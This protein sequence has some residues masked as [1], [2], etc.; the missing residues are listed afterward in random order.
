MRLDV[1]DKFAKFLTSAYRDRQC[2]GDHIVPLLDTFHQDEDE[3]TVYFVFPFLRS[4]DD[5][6]METIGD[7]IDY[8]DQIIDVR[9]CLIS[10]AG[11]NMY[12]LL[13]RALSICIL[14]IWSIGKSILALLLEI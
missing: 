3:S 11:P 6:P 8:M 13:C 1:H 14:G 4:A 9:I 2:K 12:S 7:V 5:P 10:L